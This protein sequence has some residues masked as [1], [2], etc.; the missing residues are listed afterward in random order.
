MEILVR[1]LY[2]GQQRNGAAA[3]GLAKYGHI[4][5]VAAKAGD[6]LVNPL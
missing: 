5:R 2:Q 6:V 3:G 1:T 4:F